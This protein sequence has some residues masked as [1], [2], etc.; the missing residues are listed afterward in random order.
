MQISTQLPNALS[1]PWLFVHDA[2]L[3]VKSSELLSALAQWPKLLVSAIDV[4]DIRLDNDNTSCVGLTS[5]KGKES[6][7]KRLGQN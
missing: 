3:G 4:G 7:R 5:L 6:E 1:K 2:D